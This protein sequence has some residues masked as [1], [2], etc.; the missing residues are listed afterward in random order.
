MNL[1]P[2]RLM[3]AEIAAIRSETAWLTEEKITDQAWMT[4]APSGPCFCADRFVCIKHRF[5]HE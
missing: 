1:G 4:A 5:Q 3:L 2:Q